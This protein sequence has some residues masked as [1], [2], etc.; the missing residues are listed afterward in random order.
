VVQFAVHWYK[1]IL[2]P[3][4]RTEK[5]VTTTYNLVILQSASG[6]S[7]IQSTY[8]KHAAQCCILLAG[9][10]TKVYSTRGA[11]YPQNQHKQKTNDHKI[12]GSKV[13]CHSLVSLYTADTTKFNWTSSAP[14]LSY[15]A[16]SDLPALTLRWR[17]RGEDDARDRPF[18]IRQEKGPVVTH[19]LWAIVRHGARP[20]PYCCYNSLK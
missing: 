1:V 19:F 2:I 6:M 12:T 17:F 3:G 16:A 14:C 13:A 15:Q 20:A 10:N 8:K 4:K 7:R 9:L 11:L 5:N 18:F